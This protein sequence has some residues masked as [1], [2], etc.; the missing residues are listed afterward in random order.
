MPVLSLTTDRH[1]GHLREPLAL[2][3]F[4]KKQ[5]WPG[6][7][8]TGEQVHRAKIAAV[9]ALVQPREYPGVDGLVTDVCAQPLGLF[10][11]DCVPVFLS[12]RNGEIV[13]VVHAGWRG[14]QANIVGRALNLLRRRWNVVPRDVRFWAGPF[15]GP[16]CF[17]VQWDVARY[18]PNARKRWKDR[19]RIDLGAALRRQ[20]RRAGARWK[21]TSMGC[22]MHSSRYF[23]FRRDG[24]ASR[25]VSLIMKKDRHERKP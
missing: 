8:A 4:L 24:T 22:T 18:F 1:H 21:P 7:V 16:C 6:A 14:V 17:E 10:T 13:G 25:Q 9:G 11:A 23:S 5:G 3:R 12:A 2:A 15:I 20:V 19:W